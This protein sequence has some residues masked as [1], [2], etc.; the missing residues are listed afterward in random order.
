MNKQIERAI[1]DAMAVA[2]AEEAYDARKV[3]RLTLKGSMS[4]AQAETAEYDAAMYAPSECDELAARGDVRAMRA[5]LA[6]GGWTA[7]ELVAEA[8]ARTRVRWVHFHLVGPTL[9][10]VLEAEESEKA[11]S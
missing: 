6:K 7:T 10:E 4:E 3:L 9:S 11:V 2:W 5:T 8:E 1:L